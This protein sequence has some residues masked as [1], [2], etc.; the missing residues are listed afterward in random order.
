MGER[1]VVAT[2]SMNDVPVAAALSYRSDDTLYGRHWGCA[3][4]FDSLHFELCYY[5]GIDYCIRH[6]LQRF[7]PGAQGEHKIWRGFLPV[8]TYSAHRLADPAF[9]TAVAD[10]LARETPA[11]RA[12]AEQLNQH[13]PFRES[14]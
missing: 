7:E 8:F 2:A 1:I 6:G 13:T 4:D 9:S 11:V 12:Y 14:A 10:F 3:A 5:R